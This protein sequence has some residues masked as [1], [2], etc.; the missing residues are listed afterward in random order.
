MSAPAFD[1]P[2]QGGAQSVSGGVAASSSSSSGGGDELL[3]SVHGSQRFSTRVKGAPSKLLEELIAAPQ[4]KKRRAT[5]LGRPPKGGKPGS[6][7][8][9]YEYQRMEM[10]KRQFMMGAMGNP[11]VR[12]TT[13]HM[14]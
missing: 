13:T 6:L 4:I 8:R 2:P 5:S 11:A 7:E 1:Q 9:L 10:Q 12:H 3:G 14:Q